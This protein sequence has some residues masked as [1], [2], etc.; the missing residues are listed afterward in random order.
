VVIDQ[1]RWTGN[2]VCMGEVRNAVK[3]LVRKCAGKTP[4]RISRCRWGDDISMDL[5]EMVWEGVDWNHLA[6]DRDQWW[7]LVIMVVN[8]LVP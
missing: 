1:R 4:L 3:V 5:R 6:H 8:L 7:V 2:V